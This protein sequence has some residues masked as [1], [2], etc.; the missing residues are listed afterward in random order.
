MTGGK[1]A[2]SVQPS[3]T[4]VAA[5]FLRGNVMARAVAAVGALLAAATNLPTAMI[6]AVMAL[7]TPPMGWEDFDSHV[8]GQYNETFALKAAAVQ[9]EQLLPSGY[10]VFIMGGWSAGNLTVPGSGGVSEPDRTCTFLDEYGRPN[11]AA[12]FPSA[13]R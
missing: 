2:P 13:A 9:A 10:D 4:V 7:G 3:T 5:K 11:H 1:T 12:R 6:N 8:N